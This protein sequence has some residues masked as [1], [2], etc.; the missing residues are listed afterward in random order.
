[1]NDFVG[2]VRVIINIFEILNICQST[3]YLFA[4]FSEELGMVP[5]GSLLPTALGP[6]LLCWSFVLFSLK[7]DTYT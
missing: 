5:L 4:L 1:M 6:D 3:F 2:D 7:Y